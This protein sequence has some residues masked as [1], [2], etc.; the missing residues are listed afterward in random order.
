MSLWSFLI[1]AAFVGSTLLL[2]VAAWRL[3]REQRR[4]RRIVREYE[5]LAA[6]YGMGV[7]EQ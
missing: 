7:W 1:L 4:L 3:D 6:E 2:F 5:R